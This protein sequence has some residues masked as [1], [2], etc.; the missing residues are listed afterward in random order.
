MYAPMQL[1]AVVCHVENKIFGRGEGKFSK[2][3]KQI[4]FLF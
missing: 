1:S 4:E 2:K 3:K